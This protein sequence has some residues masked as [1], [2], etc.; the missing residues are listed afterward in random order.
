[1]QPKIREEDTLGFGILIED[2]IN[3]QHPLVILSQEIQ[4]KI[5][6]EAFT[7]LYSAKTG[8]PA[9]PIR[10]MVSLL[11]L[12][13]IRNLSDESVVEQWS[14]NM[15]Y[16]HFG[17]EKFF[18]TK[19]PCEASEL[20]HFRNRIG[21]EGIEL[22]LKES[23]RING[24]DGDGQTLSADTTIQEK[25]ITYPT[26]DKLHKKIIKKCQAI[27][28]IHNL[29]LRQSY[30]T[31]IKKLSKKQRFRKSKRL[32]KSA[33]KADKKI[34][35]IAGRLVREIE[36]KLSPEDYIKWSSD[37]EI[38]KKILKQKRSQ[39]NKI[40]SIHEPQVECHSKGKEHKKYEFGNKVSILVNQK[41]G[42]IVGALSIE[43]NKHDSR[44]IQE[45]VE[46]YQRLTEGKAKE[47]YVD[48]GYRGISRFEEVAIKVAGKQTNI[49]TSQKKKHS[50]RAAIEPKIS[51]LKS[52][53]RLSRNFYKGI[54]GDKINVILAAAAMN[55]KRMMNKWKSLI[56]L[57]FEL[58][59][60]S[61]A[62]PINT[63]IQKIIQLISIDIHLQLSSQIGIKAF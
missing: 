4:W 61:I 3:L 49:S 48:R 62:N 38:F 10:L 8:R 63:Q 15:Y 13:H 11:M 36:R 50:R 47:I 57:L 17:G 6:E 26:D 46:Q 5:F 14:E 12:K 9:K 24:K 18:A 29:E 54:Q 44:T 30:R 59:I 23:I 21:S 42:V 52:D 51:H 37:I 53:H 33:Y 2:Q 35:T 25:N 31:T 56:H 39:S 28:N 27:A 45:S 1:M 16:Q 60:R 19:P 32:S 43:E 40:Y 58:I 20:V 55:F 22:I 34:K 41:T 7:K